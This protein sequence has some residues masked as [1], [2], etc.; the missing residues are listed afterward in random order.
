MIYYNYHFKFLKMQS[1]NKE[2]ISIVS[3]FLTDK[4]NLSLSK[5]DKYYYDNVPLINGTTKSIINKLKNITQ[6]EFI[7]WIERFNKNFKHMTGIIKFIEYKKKSCQL[8]KKLDE[9]KRYDLLK[10]YNI[11][12][13]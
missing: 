12:K 10:L 7:I 1:I 11:L 6:E 9:Y 2:I 4:E 3:S 5:S 13:Y 8:V